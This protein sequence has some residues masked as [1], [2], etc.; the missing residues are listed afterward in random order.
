MTRHD[1]VPPMCPVDIGVPT[2]QQV[3]LQA[4]ALDAP[5][6]EQLAAL[7][8]RSRQLRPEVG[9]AYDDL[10]A[11]LEA[12][13]VGGAAPKVGD[14]MPDFVLPDHDG[15]LTSLESLLAAGPLV[16]SFNRGHWCGY[17][18]L[19]IQALAKAQ[20]KIAELG[21]GLVSIVPER[22]EFTRQFRHNNG[23]GFPVL[24]DIDLGYALTVGLVIMLSEDVNR[25]YREAG[26]DLA[27]FQGNAGQILP[28]PAT[29]VI[30]ADGLI[31]A[32]YVDPD[33][34]RRMAMEDIV[35]ALEALQATRI[36][37]PPHR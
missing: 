4:M 22:A 37:G 8:A 21:A 1:S 11:R 6:A 5:L 17:C 29:F 36:T 3:S 30:G 26:T 2:T 27:R 24:S 19:E 9:A 33:F 28:V 25:L 18:R 31:K 12:V 10:V 23:L 35:A 13:R 14:P 34:R 15:H 20:G 16:V 32:R 7:T